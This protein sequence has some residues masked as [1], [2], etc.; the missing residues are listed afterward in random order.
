[1]SVLDEAAK[2]VH[3]DRGRDYGHPAVNHK[4]TAAMMRAFLQ[5]RY[6]PSAEFDALDTCAHNLC[7]K[8]SRL[9]NTPDHHD[10]QVDIAGYIAN[11]EMIL[12]VWA[13]QAKAIEAE[14]VDLAGG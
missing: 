7:Q 8:L 11:W 6:G 5:R 12:E 3:G 1:M 9:A 10:S 2:A 4:C 14:Y 13:E